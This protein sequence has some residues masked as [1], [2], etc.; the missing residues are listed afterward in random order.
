MTPETE[1][2]IET[3]AMFVEDQKTRRR[4]DTPEQAIEDDEYNWS[5]E[6]QAAMAQLEQ[7]QNGTLIVV[8]GV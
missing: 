2:L 7:L 5:P 6:M 3:L 1:A 8:K 4:F